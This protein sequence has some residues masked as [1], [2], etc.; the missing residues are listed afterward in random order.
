M[1]TPRDK[2]KSIIIEEH[3]KR[4]NCAMGIVSKSYPETYTCDIIVTDNS[5][6]NLANHHSNVQ[7]PMINGLSYSLPHP[8][9]KV[10][11][12]FLGN[13]DNFPFIVAVYPSTRM[14]LEGISQIPSSLINLISS[15]R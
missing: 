13:D 5:N 2:I 7:L 8:G 6:P 14:Q 10:L 12:E 9:D 3:N 1:T 4:P 11:V 15:M